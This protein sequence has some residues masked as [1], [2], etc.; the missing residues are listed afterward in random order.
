MPIHE[1]EGILQ[2]NW[3]PVKL[4]GDAQPTWMRNI[5]PDVVNSVYAS[6]SQM[7]APR[8]NIAMLPSGDLIGGIDIYR[9]APDD[10][11][12]LNKDWYAIIANKQHDD[13]LLVCGPYKDNEHWIDEIPECL[14]GAEILLVPPK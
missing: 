4:M 7:F 12:R 14:K 3:A 11:K 9:N 1:Y 5:P 2:R 8:P 6:G 10:P 13:M